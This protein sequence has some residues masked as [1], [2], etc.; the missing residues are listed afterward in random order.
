[1]ATK[2][3]RNRKEKTLTELGCSQSTLPSGSRGQ[4]NGQQPQNIV[5]E[6]LNTRKAT[7]LLAEQCTTRAGPPGRLW[8]LHPHVLHSDLQRTRTTCVPGSLCVHTL[9]NPHVEN[10]H[11]HKSPTR[12]LHQFSSALC[13]LKSAS[14]SGNK[15]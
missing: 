10:A 9:P 12:H 7:P 5:G 3:V 15:N 4:N 14:G 1:M 11:K 2:M 13:Y 8:I 6:V